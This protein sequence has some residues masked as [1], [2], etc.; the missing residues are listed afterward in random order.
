MQCPQCASEL[1]R[2]QILCDSCGAIVTGAAQARLDYE[3]LSETPEPVDLQQGYYDPPQP[4]AATSSAADMSSS[5]SPIAPPPLTLGGPAIV[6]AREAL[7]FAGNPAGSLRSTFPAALGGL[8]AGAS[9]DP[10]SPTPPL[11]TLHWLSKQPSAA[12]TPT[13][14]PAPSDIAQSAPDSAP[15][16]QPAEDFWPQPGDVRAQP[17]AKGVAQ[18][19]DYLFL[20]EAAPQQAGPT[21]VADTAPNPPP[22]VDAAGGSRF[23]AS[24]FGFTEPQNDASGLAPGAL[25]ASAAGKPKPFRSLTALLILTVM[26]LPAPVALILA[27]TSDWPRRRKIL[28]TVANVGFALAIAVGA[29]IAAFLALSSQ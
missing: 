28:F 23:G 6:P 16:P 10:A 20:P 7:P 22:P 17:S 19:L 21:S 29:A 27:W 18:S 9:V 26:I 5:G 12:A 15:L 8:A 4:L 11:N 2:A 25:A 13:E 3:S 14:T 24:R 1:G